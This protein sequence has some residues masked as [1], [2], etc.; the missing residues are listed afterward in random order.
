MNNSEALYQQ[1]QSVWYDNIERALLDDGTLAGLIEKRLIYGV[2]SNPS[3]FEKAIVGSA[4]YDD[5]LQA[6]AWAGLD[7]DQIYLQLVKEDIQ[8]TAN[9]FKGL[10]EHTNAQDGYV[11][12]E[13]NP[14][15]AHDTQGTIL[16]GKALWAQINRHN[17][18]I[19]VP[20]TPEGIPAIRALTAAGINVNATLIF[21][22]ARYQEVMEAYISGL[23]E[24]IA[25]HEEVERIHSVASFFVSRID[26]L[27]DQLLDQIAPSDPQAAQLASLLKG[28]TAI[29]YARMAYQQF[30]KTFGIERFKRLEQAGAN[31]QRPLWASTGTKNPA[32]SPV[33][34]VENLVAPQT[35][36]TVPPATLEALNA[37]CGTA[38][39][40]ENDLAQAERQL[41]Q[42][43]NLGVSMDQVTSEL[44]T[45][46][47]RKFAQAYQTLLSA[48][49]TKRLAFLKELGGLS[50][51][52]QTRLMQSSDAVIV[53]RMFA[54]DP[55]LWTDE[56]Q[57]FDDIRSRLGWLDL[58]ERSAELIPELEAFRQECLDAGYSDALVLGMGGSSLAPE[59]MSLTLGS[60]VPA[61]SGLRLQ[62]IDTTNPDE[63]RHKAEALDLKKVLL[64]VSSK[65]GT[66]SETLSALNYFWNVLEAL[67]GPAAGR[68]F[69]AITDPGTPLE[70]LAQQKGFRRVFNA[71][72]DVGGRYS[73][74]TTFGLVP[75]AVMGLDLVKLLRSGHLSQLASQPDVP[76]PANPNLMLGIVLGQAAL[77]GRDKLTF[78]TD[79]PAAALIP[80]LEQLIAESSGKQGKGILPIE[81]EPLLPD[82][83]YQSDRMFVY[84]SCGGEN[85]GMAD[86]LAQAGFPVLTLRMRSPYDLGREFYRWEYAVAI[87]CALLRVN[88]FDQP[89]VQE[90]KTIAKQKIDEYHTLGFLKE[91]SPLFED[92]LAAVYGQ[93]AEWNQGCTSAT[94]VLQRGLEIL[95]QRGYVVLSAYLERSEA[96][97]AALQSLRKKILEK[98][99]AATTL[100]F[101]PRFLHSTGQLHK[102]G[103]AGGFFIILTQDPQEA[104]TIA[105]EGMT[106]GTLQ[107]AEALGDLDALLGRGKTAIRLH[108]HGHTNPADLL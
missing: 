65:S 102:G 17:L 55:S 83:N 104:L 57:A 68:H 72:A 27:V 78:L 96:N 21:S 29:N 101:G 19:K 84:Y 9:L 64:I 100:G 28:R 77:S 49:E 82:L 89:N 98:T 41:A 56:A 47:V 66:T 91:G 48:I 92:D 44:E 15:L 43:E 31:I 108:L 33:L 14:L 37:S 61:G 80:W 40:I 2:T 35:V 93:I 12:L 103:L 69:A 90:N 13:V 58:P 59:V 42:L 67:E 18:M 20:A 30:R 26:T 74:F 25:A 105:G 54:K 71:P 87:A 24:R 1:G 95:P 60:S 23:E 107:K 46:G 11:S 81:N 36:N 51:V 85:Q 4:T 86:A 106:F 34:Y 38:V 6:M 94:Q 88:A 76:Y 70:S 45:D 22:I 97:T 32:Y 52:V 63:I 16:E 99:H 62:I 7:Q 5:S 3:I 50:P 8:R 79:P 75:A 73:A 10:Y 53:S 39:S